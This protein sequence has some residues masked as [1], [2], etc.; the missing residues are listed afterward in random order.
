MCGASVG[1][2][3][4]DYMH[5]YENYYHVEYHSDRW[6]RIANSNIIKT[7][8]DGVIILDRNG[9]RYG[10]E[11]ISALDDASRRRIYQYM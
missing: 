5:S 9:N 4:E 10:I 3:V 6:F 2:I 8:G 7:S 11:S 1:E